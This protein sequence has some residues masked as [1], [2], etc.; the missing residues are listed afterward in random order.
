MDH[1]AKVLTEK[2]REKVS[3][4]VI[5]SALAIAVIIGGGSWGGSDKFARIDASLSRIEENQEAGQERAEIRQ[6]NTEDRIDEV[7][8]IAR[9]RNTALDARIRPLE[10]Q[11][12]A[13]TA[14]LQA[15]N[16]NI[17]SLS[18]DIRDLRNALK[19]ETDKP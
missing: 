6:A 2:Q 18:A 3:V 11:A 17:I 9:D 7:V 4:G 1:E 14:T 19:E 10:A 5:A 15:I 13:T 16:N 8:T 12:A